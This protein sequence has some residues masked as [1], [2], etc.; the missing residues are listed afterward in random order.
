MKKAA[1]ILSCL[2]GILLGDIRSNAALECGER[3]VNNSTLRR[4]EISGS[5][6]EYF[7]DDH[8]ALFGWPRQTTWAEDG[9]FT[10]QPGVHDVKVYAG[11][12][13]EYSCSPLANATLIQNVWHPVI[14]TV[15]NFDNFVCG[16][17]SGS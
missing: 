1:Y 16:W 8:F 4:A 9:P 10:S 13:C 5:G 7:C 2:I 3:C 11:T 14:R 12:A 17:V 15:P 6:P